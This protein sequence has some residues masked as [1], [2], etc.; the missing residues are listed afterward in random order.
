MCYLIGGTKEKNLKVK[1]PIQ[2]PTKILR[3]RPRKMPCSIGSV[4]DLGPSKTLRHHDDPLFKLQFLQSSQNDFRPGTQSNKHWFIKTYRKRGKETLPKDR[5]VLSE[6]RGTTCLSC[7][8]VLLGTQGSF[9]RVMARSTSFLLTD[10]MMTTGV[11]SLL[12]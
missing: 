2:M 9:W 10:S 7:P 1:E 6:R 11:Q 8:Q 5:V 3:I 4:V 12:Q